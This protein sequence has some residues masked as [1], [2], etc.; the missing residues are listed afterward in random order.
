M[1][2]SAEEAPPFSVESLGSD[3]SPQKSASTPAL[4]PPE[5]GFFFAFFLLGRYGD[6]QCRDSVIPQFGPSPAVKD[7][8]V[9]RT[10]QPAGQAGGMQTEPA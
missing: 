4:A 8:D 1:E 9:P 5:L 3:F 6:K 2:Y 10:V 7:V